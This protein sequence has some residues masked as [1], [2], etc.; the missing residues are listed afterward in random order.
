MLGTFVNGFVVRRVTQSEG[1]FQ[2][3]DPDDS[4]FTTAKPVLKRQARPGLKVGRAT[5]CHAT[6][7]CVA[8]RAACLNARATAPH[9]CVCAPGHAAPQG[10]G[11]PTVLM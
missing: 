4:G 1:V 8:L 11:V 3:A 9:R 7:C 6:P 5:P 2:A 10:M